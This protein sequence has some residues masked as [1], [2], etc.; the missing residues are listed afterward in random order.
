[1]IPSEKQVIFKI[2]NTCST[3]F[4]TFSISFEEK[5]KHS[6]KS[7]KLE[8]ALAEK[9]ELISISLAANGLKLTGHLYPQQDPSLFIVYTIVWALKP[10]LGSMHT[11][12]RAQNALVTVRATLK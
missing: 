12:S 5:L 1:M 7:Q 11:G 3:S 2:N 4:S 8:N 6:R 10:P 9:A